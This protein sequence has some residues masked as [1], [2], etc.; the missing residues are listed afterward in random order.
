MKLISIIVSSTLALSGALAH[1]Q[2]NVEGNAGAGAQ[3][4]ASAPQDSAAV[5]SSGAASGSATAN[6]ANATLDAGTELNAT[7][8]KPVDAS[9]SKHGDP[10]VAT[11]TQDV[12]TKDEV[13]IA[14]GSKLIGHVT[15]AKPRESSGQAGGAAGGAAESQ[16][17]I[18]FDRAVLKNGREVPFAGT[19]QAIAAAQAATAGGAQSSDA[20]MSG[21]SRGAGSVGATGGGLVGGTVGAVGGA[22]GGVANTTSSIGGSIGSTAHAAGSLSNS[23]GAVGGLNAAGRLASGSQGVFGMKD[24]SL[25][26]AAAGSAQGSLITSST[27]NVRLDG[28]TRMLLVTSANAAENAGSPSSGQGDVP[29]ERPDK[30]TR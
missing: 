25:T 15:A 7:L 17:G 19:I 10:V 30:D 23:A 24:V 11:V 12:K 21:A 16:L 14:K 26:S 2:A 20:G 4:T 27:R 8:T 6:E 13:V 3:G 5:T 18:V 22:A 29:K 1:A 28:G 9:K